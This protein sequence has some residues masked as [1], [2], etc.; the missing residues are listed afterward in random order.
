MLNL[1]FTLDYEIHGNGDG[2]PDSLM[3]KPTYRLLKIMEKYGAKLTIFADMA[4]IIKFNEY[5]QRTNDDK[6]HF[7]KIKTQLQE[8]VLSGHDVQLHIHSSYFD[9]EFKNGKWEQYWPDYNF[10][11]L[12]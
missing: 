6:F 5:Y 7:L 10:A 8:A 4:E 2:S 3:I 11:N 12:D 9:A 1:I